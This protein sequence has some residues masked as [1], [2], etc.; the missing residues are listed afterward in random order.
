[1]NLVL[2]ALKRLAAE[3]ALVLLTGRSPVNKTRARKPKFARSC[4]GFKA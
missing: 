1:V 2:V 3:A 4:L